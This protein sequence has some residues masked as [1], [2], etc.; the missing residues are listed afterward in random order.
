MVC[1]PA[2]KSALRRLD[3]TPT[4]QNAGFPGKKCV[5]AELRSGQASSLPPDA[6]AGGE[7]FHSHSNLLAFRSGPPFPGAGRM[8]VYVCA[9]GY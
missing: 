8:G 7:A 5:P 3:G 4:K 2:A 1:V 6:C 9:K